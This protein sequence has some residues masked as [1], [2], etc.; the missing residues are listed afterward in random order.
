MTSY[1]VFFFSA[2]GNSFSIIMV[3]PLSD[4]IIVVPNY[5]INLKST[6]HQL[7]FG[8]LGKAC[9]TLAE[10]TKDRAA[11]VHYVPDN[12]KIRKTARR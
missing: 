2:F 10:N 6:N 9:Q 5:L 8:V 11:N 3:D 12:L 1:L 7:L 4:A